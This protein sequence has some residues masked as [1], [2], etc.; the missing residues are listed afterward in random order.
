[1]VT[2]GGIKASGIL[3]YKSQVKREKDSICAT[4][5][6]KSGFVALCYSLK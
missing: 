1:M 6:D 3:R 5:R 4:D 2:C